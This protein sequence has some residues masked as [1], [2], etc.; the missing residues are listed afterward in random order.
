MLGCQHVLTKYFY[1]FVQQ[2]LSLLKMNCSSQAL[3]A[4]LQSA[5]SR[6]L[7]AK[8]YHISFLPGHSS[9]IATVEPSCM[10]IRQSSELLLPSESRRHF[11]FPTSFY[12]NLP[13]DYALS[14]RRGKLSTHLESSGSSPRAQAGARPMLEYQN[15]DKHNAQTKHGDRIVRPHLSFVDTSVALMSTQVFCNGHHFGQ[16][17][18]ISN[19]SHWRKLDL[20]CSSEA[21]RV[22]MLPPHLKRRYL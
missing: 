1:F 5:H 17:D 15:C 14:H 11:D 7:M 6:N 21:S 9:T 2:P 8:I 3:S 19:H 12:A 22:P 10:T 18:N 4:A 13:R 20:V 16:F